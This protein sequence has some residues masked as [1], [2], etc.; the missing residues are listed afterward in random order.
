MISNF[1]TEIF[2]LAAKKGVLAQR[3]VVEKGEMRF[4]IASLLTTEQLAK[5]EKM[6]QQKHHMCQHG[7]HQCKLCKKGLKDET[8][9]TDKQ[10]NKIKEI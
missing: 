9:K 3:M 7:K 8:K 10:V 1:K 6:R 4:K 2:S 5:K